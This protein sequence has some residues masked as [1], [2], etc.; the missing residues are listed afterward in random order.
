M[1]D[2]STIDAPPEL[3][4][5]VAACVQWS[6]A[7]DIASP[8]DLQLTADHLRGLKSLLKQADDFFDGPIRS[9]HEL[10]K[11]LVGRKKIVTAPLAD[12]E[13]IDKRKML[14]YQQ[15]EAAAAEAERRRLQAIID[16]AAAKERQA[17]EAEATRQMNIQAEAQRKADA[18]RQ[19]AFDANAADRKR[20]AAIAA[21]AD[22]KAAEAG[23]KAADQS[24]AAASVIAPQATVQSVAPVVKGIATVTT[25]AFE[26]VDAALV[27]DQYKLIDTA[28]IGK[29]VR[30]LGS[31]ASIPGV[32]VFSNSTLSARAK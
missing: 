16:A 9:A 15:A 4:A 31:R 22:A 7:N 11:T 3:A 18:A 10:H 23:S 30:A 17:A 20:L 8:A 24:L 6:T 26:V 2:L 28:A 5:N 21:R 29:V 1:T 14:A 13:A 27:P 25:W 19:E 32:R 12:A